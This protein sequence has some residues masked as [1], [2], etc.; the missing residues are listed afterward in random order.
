MS[1]TYDPTPTAQGEPPHKRTTSLLRILVP[2]SLVLF[3]QTGCAANTPTQAY[4]AKTGPYYQDAQLCRARNPAKSPAPGADPAASLDR[5]GYLRCMNGMGYQQDAKTDPLLK[6]L[7]VC[8][9]G[10]S[11]V[12]ARGVKTVKP[13]TPAG[14]RDC[15]KHRGF[16]SAPAPATQ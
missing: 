16:P 13:Q 2:L 14:L 11:T 5:V 10:A 12:S 4:S 1:R 7:K 15:L 6:A 9:Q 8:Q 3:L